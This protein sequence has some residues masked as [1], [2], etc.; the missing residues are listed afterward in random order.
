MQLGMAGLDPPLGGASIAAL[1]RRVGGAV[2][3]FVLASITR[4]SRRA[5]GSAGR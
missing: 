4:S 1:T 2:D 5:G 3:R